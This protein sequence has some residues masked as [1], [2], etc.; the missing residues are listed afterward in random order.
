[1]DLREELVT[2][3]N[4]DLKAMTAEPDPAKAAWLGGRAQ[5]LLSVAND[6]RD[7]G[8]P[9]QDVEGTLRKRLLE[10]AEIVRQTALR[11]YAIGRIAGLNVACRLLREGHGERQHRGIPL[12]T[13]RVP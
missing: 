8:L 9:V 6:L 2:R 10:A 7:K 4:A 12:S 1:V 13:A 11:D 5:A 3:A